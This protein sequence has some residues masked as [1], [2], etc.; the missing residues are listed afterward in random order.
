MGKQKSWYASLLL[1]TDAPELVQD[2][3]LKLILRSSG[4]ELKRVKPYYPHVC[5]KHYGNLARPMRLLLL[6]VRTLFEVATEMQ[7]SVIFI[8][9]SLNTLDV[10]TNLDK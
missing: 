3:T 7:P 4:V 9:E 5:R 6:Q 8:G 1:V 2:G 10:K